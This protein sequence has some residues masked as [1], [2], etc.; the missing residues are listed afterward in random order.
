MNFSKKKILI[1][2]PD[3]DNSGTG[4]ITSS[5]SNE[6]DTFKEIIMKAKKK[7]LNQKNQLQLKRK[8]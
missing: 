8:Y 6:E 7:L 2:P 1:L 4:S 3:L 5:K